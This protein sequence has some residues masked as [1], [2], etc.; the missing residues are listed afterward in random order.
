MQPYRISIPETSADADEAMMPDQE[1]A[2]MVGRGYGIPSSNGSEAEF[3]QERP[4]KLEF[5]TNK[6]P[7]HFQP[8][9]EYMTPTSSPEL[10]LSA[11]DRLECVII[12]RK[13]ISISRFARTMQA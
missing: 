11:I 7:F 12:I 2:Q 5:D 1:P 10:S 6:H 3:V 8:I 9:D 4:P 13:S